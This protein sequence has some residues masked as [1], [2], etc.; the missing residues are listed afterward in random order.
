MS[1]VT[2]D[3]VV[4]FIRTALLLGSLDL[5]G[6]VPAEEID[7][8]TVLMGDGLDIDSVDSLD[9]LV[10]L[11]KKYGLT[12][13]ELDTPFVEQT[14]RSVGTLV[15]FVMDRLAQAEKV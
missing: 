10:A 6:D 3:A 8:S 13:P 12:L 2:R 9:I 14:C 5:A 11:E 4:E 7:E 1:E 15:D